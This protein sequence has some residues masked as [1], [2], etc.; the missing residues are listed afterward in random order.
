MSKTQRV[1]LTLPADVLAQARAASQGNLSGFVAQVLH[2]HFEDERLQLLHDALV[3]GAIANAEEDLE[4]AQ[5]FRYAEDEAVARYVP[6]YIE[7]EAD[8]VIVS[9]TAE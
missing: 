4:I 7:D 9:A 2:D 8:V 1:T 3:A 6:P 5:A